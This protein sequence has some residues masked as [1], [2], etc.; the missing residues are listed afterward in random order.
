MV[1]ERTV[2]KK[3]CEPKMEEGMERWRRACSGDLM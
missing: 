1:L 3:K 2:L